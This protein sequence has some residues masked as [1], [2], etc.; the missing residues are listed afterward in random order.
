MNDGDDWLVRQLEELGHQ[1]LPEELA[2]RTLL[3]AEAW[4]EPE[5]PGESWGATLERAAIPV[6]LFSAAA[7]FALDAWVKLVAVFGG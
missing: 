5:D 6:L 1:R 7:V 4:L 2:R 3:R